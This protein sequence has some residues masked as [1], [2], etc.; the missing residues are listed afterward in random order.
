M[1]KKLFIIPAL[2]VF[3]L[4]MFVGVAH[5]QTN[6]PNAGMLPDSPF[7]F[8]ERLS[9]GVA[10]FFTF[11]NK[12][13]AERIFNQSEE[14]LAEVEALI[15]KGK[16]EKAQ[17]IV[18]RYQERVS[19]AI[20]KAELAKKDGDK[21]V[22]DVLERI[23]KATTRHQEVLGDVYDKA[24]EAA[25]EA[26]E[27]ALEVSS[28]GYDTVLRAV[29]KERME[30]VLERVKAEVEEGKDRLEMLR[31]QGIPV[32]ELR[33]H[34]VDDIEA[35]EEDMRDVMDDMHNSVD[36]MHDV[37]E[38]MMDDEH[39]G[40]QLETREE[41]DKHDLESLRETT[42][43]AVEGLQENLE[44]SLENSTLTEKER[45]ALKQAGESAREE[46]K[47]E[48]EMEYEDSHNEDTEDEDMYELR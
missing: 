25:K 35:M 5:A 37:M 3:A 32:P 41:M 8:L 46:A 14:R 9:E 43:Q 17:E 19:K 23:A 33:V 2:A 24:P 6:L 34:D 26:I 1:L 42:K 39:E 12:A 29:S 36:D 16:S 7:Y 48:A 31:K 40:E 27:H 22:D 18:E 47:Q 20:E 10:T 13:K 45:E 4:F 21:S 30:E 28:K 15:E 44:K 38:E 11:D